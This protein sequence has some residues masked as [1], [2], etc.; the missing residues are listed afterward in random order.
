[1]LL[2]KIKPVGYHLHFPSFSKHVFKSHIMTT[3]FSHVSILFVFFN[4]SNYSRL[5]TGR[6]PW[7]VLYKPTTLGYLFIQKIQRQF[8]HFIRS[9]ASHIVI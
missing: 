9:G 5:N 6:W 4:F 1:M 3:I 2:H 8:E 7:K